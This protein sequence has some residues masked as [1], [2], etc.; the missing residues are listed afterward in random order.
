[1]RSLEPV[2]PRY[3]NT[4]YTYYEI[5]VDTVLY[6][7]VIFETRSSH[8]SSMNVIPIQCRNNTFILFDCI[9]NA[10]K[11]IYDDQLNHFADHSSTLVIILLM[12]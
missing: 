5:A 7:N 3:T 10:I 12:R 2:E 4:V 6:R 9:C 8:Y 1:M 11:R